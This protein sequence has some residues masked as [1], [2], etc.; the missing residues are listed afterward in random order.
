MR[1]LL[2]SLRIE[3]VTPMGS[4]GKQIAVIGGIVELQDVAI[5]VSVSGSPRKN[6]VIRAIAAVVGHPI[7]DVFVS[8]GV[9]PHIDSYVLVPGTAINHRPRWIG[10]VLLV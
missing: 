9:P 10:L 2:G 4:C 1:H 3:G 5:A 7:A 6:C 8:A